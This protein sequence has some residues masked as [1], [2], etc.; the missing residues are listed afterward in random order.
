[1]VC[2]A[3]RH[4]QANRACSN[5]AALDSFGSSI[6]SPHIK[7]NQ[8][9]NLHLGFWMLAT[10]GLEIMLGFLNSVHHADGPPPCCGI[11]VPETYNALINARLLFMEIDF[12]IYGFRHFSGKMTIGVWGP[13]AGFLNFSLQQIRPSGYGFS[14]PGVRNLEIIIIDVEKFG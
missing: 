10:G 9:H 11:S 12:G 6:C 5:V 8:N 2:N 4:Q 3:P 1:M 13:T 7:T 14:D